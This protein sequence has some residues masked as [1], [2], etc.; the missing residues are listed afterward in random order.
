MKA[1]HKIIVGGTLDGKRSVSEPL[2]ANDAIREF[3]R[4]KAEGY[5]LLTLTDA[6]TGKNY[7]VDN[8]IAPTGAGKH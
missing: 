6:E 7:D 5:G 3:H 2:P 1:S 4:M 8:S